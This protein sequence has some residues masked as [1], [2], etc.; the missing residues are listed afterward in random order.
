MRM[1]IA[2]DTDAAIQRVGQLFT[3]A[4]GA[5]TWQR[6]RLD[7]EDGPA[8]LVPAD[9]VDTVAAIDPAAYTAEELIAYAADK[10]WQV[11]T[12]G[13]A[14][15]GH[16]VQTDRDSQTKLIAEMVAIGAG[17]RADPSP[18]KMADGFVALTNAEM[19]DV[20][21]TVRTHIASA[22][23]TEAAVLAEIAGGTVTTPAQVDALF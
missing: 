17:L 23:A 3:A 6:M 12:G 11:E 10:R 19:L 2:Y 7:L 21:T 18:W 4:F 15:G 9:L 16:T 13:C 8:L 14:W 5:E 22:F 1:R 20:I